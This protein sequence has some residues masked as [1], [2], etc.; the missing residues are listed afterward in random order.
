MNLHETIS[1]PTDQLIKTEIEKRFIPV[2]VI[3]GVDGQFYRENRKDDIVKIC[4]E[5]LR[6]ELYSC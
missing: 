3:A 2:N 6:H 4:K 5:I 1:N